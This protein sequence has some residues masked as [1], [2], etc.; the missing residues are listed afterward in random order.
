MPTDATGEGG[1]GRTV[2]VLG[3]QLNRDLGALRDAR[4]DRDRVLIVQSAAK[5]A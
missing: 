2:W 5:L 4:P 1:P 3:D